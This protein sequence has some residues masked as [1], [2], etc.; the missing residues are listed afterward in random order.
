MMR[1]WTTA[2]TRAG[3]FTASLNARAVCRWY[4][5]LGYGLSRQLIWAWQ[6]YH[7]LSR[8]IA[9][10]SGDADI[11]TP[12]IF[13]FAGLAFALFV[14]ERF[15]SIATAMSASSWLVSS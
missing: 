6:D 4:R 10:R 2:Q 15:P 3:C 7:S 8:A 11:R 12:M 1:S 13:S 9:A 14:M 5:A